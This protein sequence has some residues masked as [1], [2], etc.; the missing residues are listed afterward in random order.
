M[1]LLDIRIGKER[2]KDKFKQAS[3]SQTTNFEFILLFA[4]V[5]SISLFQISISE[6]ENAY[7]ESHIELEKVVDVNKET[8]E[9]YITDLKNLPK[10]FPN[11]VKSVD[12]TNSNENKNLAKIVFGL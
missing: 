10:I 5:V 3:I 6:A 8:F 2:N 1:E 12:T 11:Y 7:A 4:L 9:N